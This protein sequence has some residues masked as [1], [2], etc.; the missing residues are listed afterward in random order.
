M[1]SKVVE[2]RKLDTG[3][4][5]STYIMRYLGWRLPPAAYLDEY[6]DDA[7][8]NAAV[9]RDGRARC[10]ISVQL[11]LLSFDPLLPLLLSE[12]SQRFGKRFRQAFQSWSRAHGV[13]R[14]DL[15]RK[16]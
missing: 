12:K 8:H 4:P 5:M 1:S 10:Q 6:T 15:E 13:R 2:L 14:G 11:R 9:Q 7:A 16:L 3:H